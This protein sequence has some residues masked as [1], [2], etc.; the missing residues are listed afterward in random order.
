MTRSVKIVNTSNWEHEDVEVT[1]V[2]KTETKK[3]SLQPGDTCDVGPYSDGELVS[4]IMSGVTPETP[5]PFRK[6]GGGQDFPTV[7]VH[8]PKSGDNV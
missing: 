7:E 3:V 6:E 2:S 5:V 8:K 1:V 4:V